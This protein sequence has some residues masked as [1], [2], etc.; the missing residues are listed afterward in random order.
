MKWN[1]FGFGIVIDFLG[2]HHY[3]YRYS[4]MTVSVVFCIDSDCI[5]PA[6]ERIAV[7]VMYC[8]VMCKTCVCL[9]VVS[10]CRRGGGAAGRE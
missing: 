2:C 10:G 8:G 3:L 9:T 5:V 4:M 6:L 1:S 7:A